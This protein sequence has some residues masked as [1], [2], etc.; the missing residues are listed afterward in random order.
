MKKCAKCS[1]WLP[2]TAFPTRRVNGTS[3]YCRPCQSIYCKDHY[4]R[5]SKVH[6]R[7]RC[8]N[9]ALYRARNRKLIAQYLSVNPCVDCG[10]NDL[11]VL[12]FDHVRGSKEWNISRLVQAG[13]AWQRI[14]REIA[15]CEVRCANCHRRKTVEQLGWPHAIRGVAQLGRASR[16]GREGRWFESSRPDQLCARGLTG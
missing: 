1:R 16:L 7:R 10:E 13:W 4:R 14:A 8:R 11:R 2:L 12:E 6:N 9:Q 5:N 15:K 3:S